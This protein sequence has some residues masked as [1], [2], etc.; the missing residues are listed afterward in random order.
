MSERKERWTMD[1]SRF[2]T[3]AATVTASSFVSARQLLNK[4]DELS[5]ATEITDPND[6]ESS[7][8]LQLSI[9]NGTLDQSANEAP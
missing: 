4:S 5:F 2:E 1:L 8:C 6:R 7:V 9:G 3:G